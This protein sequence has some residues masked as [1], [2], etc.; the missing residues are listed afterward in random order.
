MG[1]DM[2]SSPDPMTASVAV[3]K[4]GISALWRVSLDDFGDA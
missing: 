4:D 2:T 1:P 3:H